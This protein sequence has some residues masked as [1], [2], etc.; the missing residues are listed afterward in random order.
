MPTKKKEKAPKKAKELKSEAVIA[1]VEVEEVSPADADVE[2]ESPVEAAALVESVE[3]IK[4]A[5]FEEVLESVQAVDALE[6]DADEES[7]DEL[8]ETLVSG[9]DKKEAIKHYRDNITA[10]LREIKAAKI[11][12][13]VQIEGWS[14]A[15]KGYILNELIKSIDPRFYN[16]YVEDDEKDRS[17]YPFLYDYFNSIPQ[18]GNFRFMDGGYMQA[19]INDCFYN[20]LSKSEYK[21]RIKSL[22]NYERS[23]VNNGY[24]IIKMFLDISE[25]EQKERLTDLIDSKK[26]SWR[27]TSKDILQN[28]NYKA[29]KKAYKSFMVDNSDYVPWHIIDAKKDKDL[30]YEAF[31]LLS[32]SIDE[33]LAAGKFTGKEYEENFDL[34][35]MPK[36]A[37]VDLNAALSEEDYKKSLDYYEMKVF[38]LSSEL[39][40]K[41]IPFVLAFEGWDAAGKGGAIKRV[42]YPLDPRDFEVI[43]V[44]SPS[45]PEKERH[46]LW[47]FY[48]HLPKTGHVHI[49][50]R[51]WYG[52]VMVERL[53][54][55]CSEDDWKR[56]Y[57]EMNEFEK[58]LTDWGATVL[59]FWIQIDKDTQLER[60]NERQNT[61][62]KQWKITDEDWRNREKWDEYEV[63]IDE[64]IEKTSTSYAP[65]HIIESKDKKYARI[66]VMRILCEAME[67]A[68]KSKK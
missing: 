65:W 41:K 16:V 43:P 15:G 34:I 61:P 20:D 53:E 52:R 9:L 14:A 57:N 1:E 18:N 19:T 40:K 48:Q 59:K 11:P 62:E 60:F 28:A 55:F 6:K 23:L 2:A 7:Y 5:D 27:V 46:F 3:N 44:A 49:F 24:V 8:L 33:A 31:K 50:D 64:M 26:H 63:A 4:D 58:D 51:S 66:K 35:P 47:R 37:D 21:Q 13:I 12:F 67:N 54:G 32:D 68:L 39:Y 30:R 17:R 22:N 45:A 10:K 36:L 56:A 25:K 42:A 29:W 38:K